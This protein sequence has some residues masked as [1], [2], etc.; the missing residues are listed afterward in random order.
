MKLPK[1]H[2]RALQSQ[3]NAAHMVLAKLS[4]PS[5]LAQVAPAAE[6]FHL[7]TQNVDGLSTRALR[8]LNGTDT[9]SPQSLVEMHGRLFDV[10]CTKCDHVSLDFSSPLCAALG[11]ADR[12]H[13]DVIDAGSKETELPIPLEDLPR[14]TACGSLARPGVVWFGEEIPLITQIDDL[15]EQAN[16]CLVVGTSSTVRVTSVAPPP[17]PNARSTFDAGLAS[18]RVCVEGQGKYGQSCRFQRRAQRRH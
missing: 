9:P 3:P 10:Q 6:S 16:L 1:C 13:V 7:I 4:V 17:A 11:E 12:K 15:V 5:I 18:G 2:Y 8:A 14:C